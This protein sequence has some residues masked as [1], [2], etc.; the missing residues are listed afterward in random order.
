MA[1]ETVRTAIS[2]LASAD[3]VDSDWVI[4]TAD[5]ARRFLESFSWCRCIVSGSLDR[6]QPG[7]FAL[8]LFEIEPAAEAADSSVWIM[9]GDVPPAY[10][11]TLTNANG[12]CA[13]QSYMG[14][15]RDWVDAA[16]AGESVEDLIPV[17]HRNSTKPIAPTSEYANMLRGRLDFLEREVLP[18]YADELEP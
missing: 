18:L 13:V 16:S 2:D 5:E 9:V 12:A 4:K 1:N 14:A 11:D 8:F 7:I 17:Y 10:L 15:M 3:L 6:Y